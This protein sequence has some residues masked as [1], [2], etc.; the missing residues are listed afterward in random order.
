MRGQRRG[1]HR[2]P[3]GQAE[4]RL[5]QRHVGDRAQTQPG[6][7]G[8]LVRVRDR[9]EHGPA[10]QRGAHPDPGTGRREQR[11]GPDRGRTGR[12]PHR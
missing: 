10:A 11:R 4:Q 8:G 1:G 9:G 2:Q 6:T 7:P 5:Q 12:S 3:G